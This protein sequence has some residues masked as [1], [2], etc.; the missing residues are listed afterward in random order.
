M[1]PNKKIRYGTYKNHL[2]NRN[3]QSHIHLKRQA[4][5]SS[6][7]ETLTVKLWNQY[8][9][10]CD[11]SW[12]VESITCWD[13]ESTYGLFSSASSNCPMASPDMVTNT[14]NTPFLTSKDQ[15][16]RSKEVNIKSLNK[17]LNFK[18]QMNR[19]LAS[20]SIYPCST[21]Q[22][23]CSIV[24]FFF[25]SVAF[26]TTFLARDKQNMSP[27]TLLCAT[28]LPHCSDPAILSNA[29]PCRC[30]LYGYH[31]RFE[32]IYSGI[33]SNSIWFLFKFTDQIYVFEMKNI[34]CIKIPQLVK[35]DSL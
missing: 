13:R 24:A 15:K 19:G 3:I 32:C 33:E 23:L 28:A 35:F 30:C 14:Y 4:G 34:Y 27:C 6:M 10:M 5:H 8:L 26:F 16:G 20:T 29:L 9:W 22:P 25:I 21:L 17:L 7:I 18:I 11:S 31:F 1:K 2:R 12:K